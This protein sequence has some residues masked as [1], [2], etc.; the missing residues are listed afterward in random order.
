[1]RHYRRRNSGSER[2]KKIMFRI[3][4]V[5]IAAAVITFGTIL[6]GNYLQIKL[7]RLNAELDAA[8][9]TADQEEPLFSDEPDNNLYNSPNVFGASMKLADY[10]SEDEAVLAVNVLAE[11]YD[12]IMLHITD[13]DGMLLYQ[14][15][16]LCELNRM[17]SMEENTE[18]KLFCSIAAAVKAKDKRLC[19]LLTPNFSTGSLESAAWTD[20]TLIAEMALYGVDEILITLPDETVLTGT[21]AE[22]LHE[23]INDCRKISDDACPIGMLLSA[24]FYLDTNDAK[25]IQHIANAASFLAISFP[26]KADDPM[27]TV[28]RY[29]SDSITS[30]LGSFNVYN[31]RVILDGDIKILAAKYEACKTGGITNV[32][33]ADTILPSDLEYR[34]QADETEPATV[35][36]TPDPDANTNPYAARVPEETEAETEPSVEPD[37]PDSAASDTTDS[38]TMPWY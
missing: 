6:L 33:F 5:L 22:S 4:F 37:Y 14:S 11:A 27:G 28:Y 25:Q 36:E 2:V 38:G 32:C 30:L 10:E 16:A 23:Y 3:L 20:G 17:P 1:M 29:V 21:V 24:D 18:F 15:P 19:V 35:P 13:A 7:S 12:T 34:A 26:T 8:E 9:E 31:M